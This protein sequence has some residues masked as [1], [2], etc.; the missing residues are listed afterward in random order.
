MCGEASERELIECREEEIREEEGT[1]PLPVTLPRSERRALGGRDL[2]A[3][4][5]SPRSITIRG[6]RAWER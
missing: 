1:R 5:G 3:G 6:T 2:V 4:V